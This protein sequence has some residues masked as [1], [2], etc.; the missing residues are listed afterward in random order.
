MGK[1]L[2][3]EDST[4]RRPARQRYR[5]KRR[6]PCLGRDWRA[7]GPVPSAA[8]RV[9]QLLISAIIERL[10]PRRPMRES[11]GMVDALALGASGATRESSSLSFRTSGSNGTGISIRIGQ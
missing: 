9:G 5:R 4:V 2:L 11:G 6:V 1:L 7:M 10:F 3:S 8:P